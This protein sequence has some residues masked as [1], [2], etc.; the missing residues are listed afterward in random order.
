MKKHTRI[1]LNIVAISLMA[2]GPVL[3][4]LPGPQVLSWLGLMLF[5][6][7]NKDYLKKYKWFRKC[8]FKVNMWKVDRKF[9]KQEKLLYNKYKKRGK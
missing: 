3:M 7:A 5:I 2:T 8:E 6:Y 4:I 9:K 1:I